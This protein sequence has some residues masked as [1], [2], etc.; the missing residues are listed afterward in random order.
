MKRT[1][2]LLLTAVIFLTPTVS[3][4]AWGD[5]G[6]QTVGK[7]ASLRIKPRTAQKIAQILKPGETLANVA[8]WADS[9][10]ERMG[11]SDPDPDTNAFLQDIAHNEKNREWRVVSENQDKTVFLHGICSPPA[12]LG[13]SHQAAAR[14]PT[15]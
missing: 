6:H 3:A 15:S 1:L 5:D 12:T 9:V 2:S 7:I 11:K 8:S 13:F 14:R 10:K 4:L